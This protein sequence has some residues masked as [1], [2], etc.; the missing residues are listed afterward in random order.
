[1][2]YASLPHFVFSKYSVRILF[3]LFVTAFEYEVLKMALIYAQ[4]T[5]NKLIYYVNYRL[6]NGH[7]GRKINIVIKNTSTQYSDYV[8]NVT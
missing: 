7:H 8:F 2:N 5:A 6:D 3:L 1:M 4:E